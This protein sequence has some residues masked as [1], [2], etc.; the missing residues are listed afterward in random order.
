VI[1]T[2]EH[3]AYNNSWENRM[4]GRTFVRLAFANPVSAGY[5][6]LVGGTVAF[7]G[8]VTVFSPDPGFVWVWPAFVTAPVFF[9]VPLIGEAV[10]GLDAPVWFLA[11][12]LLA[13]A[14]IQSFALGALYRAVRRSK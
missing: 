8:A 7:A 3:G 1:T 10:W 5:L 11:G 4:R 13:S 9:A 2:S 12:G 14:A 6:V